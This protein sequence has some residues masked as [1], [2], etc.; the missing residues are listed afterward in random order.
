MTLPAVQDCSFEGHR[1]QLE[2]HSS[3]DPI[4]APQLAAAGGVW[5]PTETRIFDRLLA[6]ARV[7]FDVGANVGW[8]TTIASQTL[9]AQGQVFAF[10]PDPGTSALLESN[11][12]RNG[13]TNVRIIRTALSDRP[14]EAA[15]DTSAHPGD[16]HIAQGPAPTG[17]TVLLTTIDAFCA[18]HAVEIDVLKMDVQGAEP[19]VLAGM[20]KTL[21]RQR[22]KPC[23]LSEFWP[24]GIKRGGSSATIYLNTLEAL[25]YEALVIES[26]HLYDVS[27]SAL[28]HR[29]R[30]DFV[31]KDSKFVDLVLVPKGDSRRAAIT[32]LVVPLSSAQR[33]WQ[34]WVE[35]V[36]T[37]SRRA[38]RRRFPRQA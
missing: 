4:F 13:L 26:G 10:E 33:A 3:G 22:R 15:W 35:P 1:F 29:L 24:W 8:Y 20:M 17:A 2:V 32:P 11:L 37:S 9:G 23:I 28:R 25:G 7:V 38:L 14:G 36:A 12:A 16:F 18:E 27:Y 19:R 34:F 21:Q 30:T 31:S 6:D 5:E